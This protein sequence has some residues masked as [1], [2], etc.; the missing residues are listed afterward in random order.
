MATAWLCTCSADAQMTELPLAMIAPP[1]YRLMN[2][3]RGGTMA[4]TTTGAAGMTIREVKTKADRKTFV[5]L[6]FRL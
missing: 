1:V 3:A 5:D 4:G 2:R 6:P